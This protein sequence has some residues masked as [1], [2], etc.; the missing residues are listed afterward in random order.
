MEEETQ[1]AEEELLAETNEAKAKHATLL[2]ARLTSRPG[3]QLVQEA[4]AKVEELERRA[5]GRKWQPSGEWRSVAA[6]A[7]AAVCKEEAEAEAEAEARRLRAAA[8]LCL[9]C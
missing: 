9:V 3:R 2:A 5:M 6:A 8:S 4:K 1:R 7:R